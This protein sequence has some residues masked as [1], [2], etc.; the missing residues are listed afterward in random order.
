MT[1]SIC[2]VNRHYYSNADCTSAIQYTTNAPF[3]NDECIT[4]GPTS[5]YRV[6]SC[7]TE[8]FSYNIYSS[9]SCQGSHSGNTWT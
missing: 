3:I 5:T 7:T 1:T 6:S 8:M 2:L 9:D 4:M